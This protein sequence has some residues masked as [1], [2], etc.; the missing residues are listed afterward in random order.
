MQNLSLKKWNISKPNKNIVSNLIDKYSIPTI[1]AVLLQVRGYSEEKIKDLFNENYELENPF[2]FID[3]DKAVNRIKKAL[4]NFE[5]ICIY[6]DYDADGTTATSL[7]YLYLERC[8]A[9]V[10]YYIP[11]RKNE[12]Y[13]LNT[14]AIDKLKQENVNLI[15]TVDNG[16][17]AI[18]EV[19]HAS[20]LGI[21]VIITDHHQVPEKIPNA[22]AVVD[23]HRKD[24]K[25]Q[26]KN[27]A[28]VGVVFFLVL[29]LEYEDT[30][31]EFL[32]EC[33]S[34][35]VLI[36]TIG[37][38]VPLEGANRF[39]V[40]KGLEYIL[41][42]DKIG[43]NTL[44]EKVGLFNKDLNSEDIAFGIVPRINAP[45]R[46]NSANEIVN[47][48]I[49]EDF[50]EILSLSNKIEQENI[51]R[52]ELESEIFDQAEMLL[53]KEPSRLTEKIIIVEGHN[54]HSGV[55]G[56]VASRITEKYGKPSIVISIDNDVAKASGRSIEGFSLYDAI[57]ACSSYLIRFGG[58]PL[59]AG[60]EIKS[61]DIQ[62]LKKDISLFTKEYGT[63]PHP[64]LNIDC[65]LN[66]QALSLDL[67][68]QIYD[69]EPFGKDNSAP[70]FA[71]CKLVIEEIC[72]IGGGKHL[73]IRFK[74]GDQK[75]TAIKFKT[76]LDTF[77]L[78]KGDTVDIAVSLHRNVYNSCESLSI[79]IKDI[80]LSDLDTEYLINE[81]DLYESF[82]RDENL[83]DNKFLFALPTRD[84]FSTVY[85]YLKSKKTIKNEIFT[86]WSKFKV[87][88]ISLFK[89]FIIIDVFAE[90]NLISLQKDYFIYEIKVNFSAQKVNLE[91]SLI[92]KKL[93]EG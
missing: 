74:K 83:S 69:L 4:D 50:E 42:S 79:F 56:I 43:L 54:W 31:I 26:F 35:L 23:P 37:D 78:N 46:L 92:L 39:F 67:I 19:S 8:G 30:D 25:S 52:K 28:G 62:R 86:L 64:I 59:A 90:M 20:K 9:D 32:L 80:K 2:N 73:R 89:L 49:S 38:V 85:K 22:V 93:K 48:F 76:S 18:N 61:T 81:T 84:D 36:G 7:L 12:G 65:K 24:C 29:A 34:D 91:D 3:M 75:I 58:H 68:D 41:N 51:K 40:K 14:Q 70:L 63:M 13:G 60:F 17:T 44:L 33:Y 87:H 55:I 10:I 82:C 88:G 27:L 71:I 11:S 66:I 6:G 21:D 5:K 45:G 57:N 15:I 1:L 77:S 47:L 53:K 72:P 16:I